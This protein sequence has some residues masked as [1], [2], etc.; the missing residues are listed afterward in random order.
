M[1][2]GVEK[3]VFVACMMAR[4]RCP[5]GALGFVWIETQLLCPG[6]SPRDLHGSERTFLVEKATH[7]AF[8]PS[9]P[10]PESHQDRN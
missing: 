5:P 4:R 10:L 6:M 7:M 8:G 9:L 2:T 1:C 3:E